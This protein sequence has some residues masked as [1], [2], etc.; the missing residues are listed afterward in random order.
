MA[1]KGSTAVSRNPSTVK[2]KSIL[3]E[4]G[5]QTNN[6]D[7][8]TARK[9]PPTA[10][11]TDRTTSAS[12]ASPRR[13]TAVPASPRRASVAPTIPASPRRASV[14]PASPLTNKS[15]TVRPSKTP[16]NKDPPSTRRRSVVPA[17][18]TSTSKSPLAHRSP[19]HSKR[20]STAGG[21]SEQTINERG[22]E[23]LLE[24][25]EKEIEALKQENKQKVSLL[26]QEIETLKKQLD[27]SIKETNNKDKEQSDQ[28][29]MEDKLEEYEKTVEK[30]K[31]YEKTTEK[32]REEYEKETKKLNSELETQKTEYQ[33]GEADFKLR[34]EEMV[35]QIDSIKQ[36]NDQLKIELKAKI[37][38]LDR[39]VS[40][41]AETNK[42][43]QSLEEQVQTMEKSQTNSHL[44]KLENELTSATSALV[45]HKR[46]SQHQLETLELRQREELRQL[47]SGTDDTA[48]AWLEK[49]KATQQQ[50]HS[51][52]DELQKEKSNHEHDVKT[53][54]QEY[55]GQIRTLQETCSQKEQEI[56]E[57]TSQIENLLDRVETL[58]NSL[59][60]ATTR[61]EHTTKSTPSSSSTPEEINMAKDQEAGQ[62]TACLERY[63][64]K[65]KEL[66]D[67]KSRLAE[68]KETHETQLNRLGQEKANDIQELRK[69]IMRLEKRASD[70]K[71]TTGV[72]EERLVRMAEQHKKEIS[73]M[74]DQYQ[75]AIDTKNKELED[76]AYRVKAVVASKQKEV[77][78][79]ESKR[80]A[81]IERYE[82][83]TNELE[84]EVEDIKKGCSSHRDENAQLL[85]LV[86]QLQ[87][88][89]QQVN[90]SS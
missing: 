59:E 18:S 37:E 14:V 70:S 90:T 6:T 63:K 48:M 34:N 74:H 17:S 66:E 33:N 28:L 11:K 9:A 3:S 76:Y 36:E 87:V 83:K 12:I 5:I 2:R 7:R 8:P 57:R 38:E 84:N 88:E 32:L 41:L 62:H 23:E 85:K 81:E 72:N 82:L 16:L 56:D 24:Q 78:N 79:M 49:T 51:L 30:L 19:S 52:H 27:S 40:K 73:M 13:A 4:I 42:R 68:I 10:I 43:A 22:S 25:K 1:E 50:V 71:P 44:R 29:N 54:R 39:Y 67:L 35:N 31:E 89:L 77:E 69:T 61:L 47:Q 65:Q 20:I 46:Q 80:K 58:Q 53:V 60:A 15:K 86:N 75:L 26:Q 21:L 45:E 55:E 64:S